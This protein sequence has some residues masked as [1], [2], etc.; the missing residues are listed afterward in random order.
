MEW[1]P[2]HT[3]ATLMR[4]IVFKLPL[5]LQQRLRL[6]L[7]LRLL[8]THFEAHMFIHLKYCACRALAP[9]ALVPTSVFHKVR[10]PFSNAKASEWKV[11]HRS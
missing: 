5:P 11:L 10:D 2:N 4:L 3:L 6:R 8:H 9:V 1:L 7:R